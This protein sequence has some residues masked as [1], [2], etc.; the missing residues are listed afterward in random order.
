MPPESA[1]GDAS[2]PIMIEAQELSKFYGDFA[3]TRRASLGIR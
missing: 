1:A 3:A 2:Q